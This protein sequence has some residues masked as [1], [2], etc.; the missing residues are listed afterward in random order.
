MKNRLASIGHAGP[1]PREFWKPNAESQ[2][3]WFIR[4]D[5]EV[6][7]PY[8]TSVL[9]SMH[10]ARTVDEKTPAWYAS[11][12]L[13]LEALGFDPS[14]VDVD[15]PMEAGRSPPAI[16]AWLAAC[17]PFLGIVAGAL[18][19][20]HLRSYGIDLLWIAAALQLVLVEADL[21]ALQWAGINTSR[22]GP[23]ALVPTYLTSRAC[24]L[25][26]LPRQAATWWVAF[27]LAML[28]ILVC[29]S[30]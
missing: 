11:G 5:T 24:E 13:P 28:V 1:T 8:T 26:Q 2:P 30:G 15:L 25:G 22:M 27:S 12:W 6:R 3:V 9:E 20:L 23:P 29:L 7:G 14:A 16:Y 19:R 17:V 10:R 18:V 4:L 21:F